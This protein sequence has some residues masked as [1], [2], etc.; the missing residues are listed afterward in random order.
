MTPHS[1]D[2]KGLTCAPEV[3]NRQ[4]ESFGSWQ[5]VMLEFGQAL[6]LCHLHADLVLLYCEARSLTIEQELATGGEKCI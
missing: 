4:P 3:L 2:G 1:I 5:Q 6:F